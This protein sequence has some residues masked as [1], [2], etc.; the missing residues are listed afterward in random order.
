[1]E[2]AITKGVPGVTVVTP[3]DYYST[4][5]QA[6]GWVTDPAIGA[7]L[8][9]DITCLASASAAQGGPGEVIIVAHSMGGLAVRCAVDQACVGQGHK[10][11]NADQIGLV[12]TLGTPNLGS[13]FANVAQWVPQQK[14][15]VKAPGAVETAE[16]FL[17]RQLPGCPQLAAKFATP[18][19]MKRSHSRIATR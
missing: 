1:M 9:T 12:V 15:H 2:E 7:A 4:A 14:A 10:A 3:F 16:A 19:C 17:C 6:T 5:H 8:A 11:A 13:A 18:D